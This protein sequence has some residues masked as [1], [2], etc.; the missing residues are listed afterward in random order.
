VSN[1]KTRAG[2][3]TGSTVVAAIEGSN[4][5]PLSTKETKCVFT[6]VVDN[7]TARKDEN[8]IYGNTNIES[9]NDV[10]LF[11][12]TDTG[13]DC[14]GYI[15]SFKMSCVPILKLVTVTSGTIL[16]LNN[17]RFKFSTTLVV[18]N[19]TEADLTV[20]M[21]GKTEQDIIKDPTENEIY[22]TTAEHSVTLATH[23]KRVFVRILF[24]PSIWEPSDVFP[25]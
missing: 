3:T 18:E 20:T 12:D 25:A 13:N 8:T 15:T 4:V 7:S 17:N 24:S 16:N 19:M 22:I 23:K 6:F 14:S 9:R 21:D 1:I 5:L 2:S 10:E 11:T